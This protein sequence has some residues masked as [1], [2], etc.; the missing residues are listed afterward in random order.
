MTETSWS[1]SLSAYVRIIR[2]PNMY[3]Y[4]FFVPKHIQKSSEGSQFGSQFLLC[5]RFGVRDQWCGLKICLS[6]R[7]RSFVMV[8]NELFVK[9]FS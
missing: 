1:I 3:C 4:L 2:N 5:L 7:S 9:T 6:Y 8:L